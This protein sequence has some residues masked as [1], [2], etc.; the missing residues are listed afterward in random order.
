VSRSPQNSAIGGRDDT[1][2]ASLYR[3]RFLNGCNART[4]LPKFDWPTAKFVVIGTEGGFL[5]DAPVT[6]DSLLVSPAERFDVL[7]DFSAFT[8]GQEVVLMNLGPD[9][10]AGTGPKKTPEDFFTGPAVPAYPWENAWKETV[11]ADHGMVTRVIANFDIAGLY[12]WHC[13]I[14]EHEENEMM[15]P[16]L[17]LP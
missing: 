11:F 8:P 7:V 17:V 6:Q 14:L 1:A 3:F 13:H 5:S 15:R 4:L 16:L 2:P 10:P 12:V 9:E